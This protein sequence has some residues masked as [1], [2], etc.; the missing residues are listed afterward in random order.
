MLRHLQYRVLLQ[1]WEHE[2]CINLLRP[3]YCQMLIY[4][5]ILIVSI[6][7]NC[8]TSISSRSRPLS[9]QE[10]CDLLWLAA[11]SHASKEKTP[12]TALIQ[13]QFFRRERM[14][15]ILALQPLH[16]R[17]GRELIARRYKIQEIW[18]NDVQCYKKLV[19]DLIFQP[20]SRQ[21]H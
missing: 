18:S 15:P 14:D 8:V 20:I 4:N 5:W 11:A 7:I 13:W 2:S 16:L 3:Q 19:E 10:L 21:V 9:I 1:F 17:I 12:A 6:D